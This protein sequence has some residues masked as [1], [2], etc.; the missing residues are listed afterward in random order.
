ME[1][2][3]LGKTEIEEL[4][5]LRA[6][7]EAHPYCLREMIEMNNSGKRIEKGVN[8]TCVIPNDIKIVLTVEEQ[9]G[10]VGYTYHFSFSR[11]APHYVSQKAVLML[12]KAMGFDFEIHDAMHFWI[13]HDVGDCHGQ[14]TDAVN[15][16]FEKE[17]AAE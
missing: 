15:L 9:P 16:L 5:E 2:V 13:E 6:T 17:E 7:A 1:L 4:R 14:A 8:F 12:M 3:I 10:M 11:P